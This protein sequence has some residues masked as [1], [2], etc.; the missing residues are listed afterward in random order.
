MES[1]SE[2]LE[3]INARI[4]AACE[5]AGRSADSVT[6]IGAA[7][8]VEAARVLA[9]ARAGLR[10]IGENYLQEALAKQRELEEE[11]ALRWHFIGALQSNKA[12]DAVGKFALIHSVDRLSPARALQKELEK[13]AA[14]QDVLLQINIGEESTKSGCAPNALPQLLQ[15][16]R[17]LSQLRVLGLTCLPP[18]DENAEKTRPYF[19]KMRELAQDN[20]GETALLSMGMSNNYEVAIEEGATHIRIGT[21]LF[22]TRPQARK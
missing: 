10:D 17:D 6:L 13:R 21:A 3:K 5:R 15:A 1:P 9:F 12:R 8:T 20:F 4:F 11:T 14:T 19:Q 16:C 7:K 18:F 22:G 2:V